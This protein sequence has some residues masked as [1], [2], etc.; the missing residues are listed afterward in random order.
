MP[1]I[2]SDVSNI[3]S[4]N[5]KA[6]YRPPPPSTSRHLAL[7]LSTHPSYEPM[8]IYDEMNITGC[9]QHLLNHS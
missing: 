5:Y 8:P 1:A 4:D 2:L 3:L 6:P 9:K 7:C